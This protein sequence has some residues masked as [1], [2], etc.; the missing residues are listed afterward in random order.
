M[1]PNRSTPSLSPHRFV[2]NRDFRA[3]R[4]GPRDPV[5]YPDP[6]HASVLARAMFVRARWLR[7][8]VIKTAVRVEFTTSY[9]QSYLAKMNLLRDALSFGQ[10]PLRSAANGFGPAGSFAGAQANST[11][12]A[13]VAQ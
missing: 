13:A 8:D 12:H 2:Q 9:W 11:V 7:R 4:D 1:F 5:E 3:P 10:G 6:G